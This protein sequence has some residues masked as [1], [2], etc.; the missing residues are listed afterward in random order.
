MMRVV[1]IEDEKAAAK[2]LMYLIDEVAPELKIVEV[3]Q[4]VSKAITYFKSQP[5][6]DLVFMDI[7]LADGISFDIFEA[8]P[9]NYPIIFTTAYDEYAIKAFKVNSID[10]LL[11][12]IDEEALLAAITKFKSQREAPQSN[13]QLKAMLDLLQQKTPQYRS[14]YLVRRRDT[15]TPLAIDLVAFFTIEAGI[16]MAFA[17]DGKRY[18]IDKKLEDIEAEIDPKQFFRANRQ[19]IVNRQDIENFQLH[20]NGKLIINTI[21][22]SDQQIIVSRDKAP[23][24][25]TWIDN[26]Y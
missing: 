19:F 25:K 3:I 6:I 18:V 2:N 14:T 24:F 26:P 11:K 4:T 17:Q 21:P 10:Y 20:F 9:M 22:R 8:V 12:P 23:L 15:I 7:H 5:E 16:V 13:Q 1:I